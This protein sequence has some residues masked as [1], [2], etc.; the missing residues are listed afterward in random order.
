M[1]PIRWWSNFGRLR[2]FQLTSHQVKYVHNKLFEGRQALQVSPYF[3]IATN[4][5]SNIKSLTQYA[6]WIHTLS[7]NQ[8][9]AYH[10][11]IK[12]IEHSMSWKSKKGCE[13]QAYCQS[14]SCRSV[15]HAQ[16]NT[17]FCSEKSP[18]IK[19]PSLKWGDCCMYPAPNTSQVVQEQSSWTL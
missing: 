6:S 10:R 1:T 7:I 2:P 9:M 19:V 16:A 13:M 8:V 3:Q 17:A 11:L 12:I 14:N 4:L 5:T 18:W 15:L